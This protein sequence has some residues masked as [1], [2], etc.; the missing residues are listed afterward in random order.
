MFIFNKIESNTVLLAGEL[1]VSNDVTLFGTSARI[2][3]VVVCR[4]RAQP[5]TGTTASQ[6]TTEI[7]LLYKINSLLLVGLETNCTTALGC[8]RTHSLQV[9]W[10]AATIKSIRQ[11]HSAD[12]INQQGVWIPT[13]PSVQ[14]SS[15]YLFLCQAAQLISLC[16][17]SFLTQ[18]TPRRL[19]WGGTLTLRKITPFKT[20]NLRWQHGG[21]ARVGVNAPELWLLPLV[22]PHWQE[23]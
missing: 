10:D 22:Q 23:S 15:I 2:A 6:S 19:W 5:S 20:S 4:E 3:A 1:L 12:S 14:P 8:Q 11:L 17:I 16:Q 21:K 18:N 9:T 7:W 13:D